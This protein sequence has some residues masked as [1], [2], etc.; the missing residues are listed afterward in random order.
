MEQGWVA[1]VGPELE[2]NLS[3]RS[4]AATLERAGIKSRIIRFDGASQFGT[5]VSALTD[6]DDPPF[7]IGISLA[8]QWRAME[9]L[10]LAIALREAGSRAHFTSGGHFATFASTEILTDFPELDS[11]CR[12]EA[13]ET[14]VELASALREGRDWQTLPGLALRVDGKVVL[15]E[16]RPSPE[17]ASLPWPVRDPEG[18]VVHGRRL[19]PLVS[20]RGCYANCSFCCIA[21][22][23][24]AA[25]P[26][27]RYRFRPIDDVADEMAHLHHDLGVGIFVFHDDNF[28]L[29]RE[30]DNLER[31][32]A[33]AEA[34]EA[35]KLGRYAT[36]I[37]ARPM[38]VTPKVFS[39]LTER[40][41]CVRAYVGIETDTD[42]GLV[43]LR[44]GLKKGVNERAMEVIDE[45]GLFVSFN[46]LLFDPD[47]TVASLEENLRFLERHAHHPF[48]FGRVELYAGTPLLGRMQREGRASGDW[49]LW[50]YSIVDPTIQR[51]FEVTNDAFYD[52]NFGADPAAYVAMALRGDVALA[53]HFSPERYRPRW[54]EETQ[55]ISRQLGEDSVQVLRRIIAGVEADRSRHAMVAEAKAQLAQTDLEVRRRA[56]AVADDIHRELGVETLTSRDID[57]ATPLQLGRVDDRAERVARTRSVFSE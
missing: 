20:S 4:L 6:T 56:K 3:L 44:R 5:V 28:F 23:H 43:T 25:T 13:D 54:L 57:L 21:A 48:N 40:L 9:L 19:A 8:F 26:G 16:K 50:N 47:T 12:Q 2:E 42:Q 27:K 52:R 33:L 34:L 35:R 32:T 45:L 49:L 10:G 14:I 30:R 29:P 38:D 11:I 46:M 22:W 17:L 41:H 51:V 24:E 7:L 55:A 39:L 31:L 53:R 36:V 1:L 18:M 15:T 37:K